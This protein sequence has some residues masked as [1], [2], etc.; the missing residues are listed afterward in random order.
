MEE[1]NQLSFTITSSLSPVVNKQVGTITHARGTL[2]Y[3]GVILAF[4]AREE[5]SKQID[6]TALQGRKMT[7]SSFSG[8]IVFPT[9][10]LRSLLASLPLWSTTI[11]RAAS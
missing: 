10:N 8:R 5:S 11:P 3:V 6:M 1:G 7:P 9:E 4:L 2:L